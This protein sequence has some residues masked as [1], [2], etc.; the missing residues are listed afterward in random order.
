[1]FIFWNQAQAAE[2]KCS[3]MAETPGEAIDTGIILQPCFL[4]PR[5]SALIWD[6]FG[7][8]VMRNMDIKVKWMDQFIQGKESD[9]FGTWQETIAISNKARDTSVGEDA[10]LDWMYTIMN[11]ALVLSITQ[12]SYV[13][14]HLSLQQVESQ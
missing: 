10:R 11:K 12:R 4:D 9:R 8:V 2:G 6:I 13:C 5:Y 1:M 14:A 7:I 3:L